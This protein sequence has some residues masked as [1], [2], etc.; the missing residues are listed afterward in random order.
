MTLMPEHIAYH[1]TAPTM[2][3][4]RAFVEMCLPGK[5]FGKLRPPSA[6]V[7]E[8]P[9]VFGEITTERVRLDHHRDASGLH[10]PAVC[11]SDHCVDRNPSADEWNRLPAAN[12]GD[13]VVAAE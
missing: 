11:T 6:A 9:P 13:F 5:D 3:Q 1:I 2:L 7:F 8:S 4:L 12:L 10:R